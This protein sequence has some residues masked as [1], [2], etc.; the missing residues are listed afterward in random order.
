MDADWT[1]KKIIGQGGNGN[2]YR[3]R[4]S[5]GNFYA[6][7]FL[8]NVK[9]DKAY[10]RFK[11]EI[12]VL[13][14]LADTKGVIKILE[15][16]LPERITRKDKP[17]Y[18][19]PLGTRLDEYLKYKTHTQFYSIL[20]KLA[21]TL[22]LLHELDITHRDIKPENILVIEDEPVFSDFGLAHFP[23]KEKVSDLK[24]KIG[25]KWTIA[26]EMKRISSSAQF[27]KADIYSFAKTLWIL[28]TK[29]NSGF[30]GQYIAKS[31]ISIDNY[32]KLK[33]ND[34]Y[35]VIGEWEYQS[36]VLLESLL[37]DSTNNDPHQRPDAIDFLER[38]ERWYNTSAIFHKRNVYEWEHCLARIFPMSIP[39]NCSWSKIN[40]IYKI[41]QL[42]S[43]E[44]DNLNYTFFPEHGGNDF[45]QIDLAIENKTLLI[46]DYIILN[47][48]RLVFE[49]MGNL[50]F[51]YFMLELNDVLPICKNERNNICETIY[52]KKNGKYSITEK[53][54]YKKITRYLSG[55]FV[56][57]RKTSI[58]NQIRGDYDGHFGIHSKK[59]KDDYKK[60]VMKFVEVFEN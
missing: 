22:A 34:P 15:Y 20:I 21:K 53:S 40:E 36:I 12:E 52:M 30:E 41:L 57:T 46:N 33:I 3:I 18:V 2:V 47:P 49:S 4:K 6:V 29:Q 10:S 58:L 48:K 13:K 45:V 39:E 14:R 56:I 31:S 25:P 35:H 54:S 43:K 60:L 38:L 23:K 9:A 42:L 50:D 28:I 5:D 59:A 32:V 37:I 27:K 17:Y 8:T 51:S 26:P 24:E 16:N 44:Y 7:K 19:M 55:S 11:D 1:E